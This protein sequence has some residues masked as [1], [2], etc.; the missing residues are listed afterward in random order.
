MVGEYERA[1]YGDQ[2]HT[3]LSTLA[4]DGVQLWLPEAGGPVDLDDPTHQALMLLLG[5]QSRREVL[6]ARHRTLAAMRAQVCLQGRFLGG[7]P[8]YGY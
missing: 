1:F 2:F 8:P 6:R 7:R 3:V 4:R 5:A